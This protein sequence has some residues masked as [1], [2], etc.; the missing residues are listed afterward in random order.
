MEAPETVAEAHGQFI[1]A[2]AEVITTNSYALVPFHIGEERFARDGA[3]LV[4][5]CGRLA[6][7]A[8]DAAGRP[9]KVA[10]SLPPI[11][12]SYRPDLFDAAAAPG[13]FRC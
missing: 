6:R 1:A 8:A 3:R 12:G 7:R 4:D 13:S 5:L 11:F 2:G 9:V 10:G